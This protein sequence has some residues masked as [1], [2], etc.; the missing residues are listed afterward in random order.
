MTLKDPKRVQASKLLTLSPTKEHG[1]YNI[2]PE[3]LD[4]V[5]ELNDMGLATTGS[6]A[7]HGEA[8]C[9]LPYVIG[10][11]YPKQRRGFI[12]FARKLNASEV[13]LVRKH[14]K[15]HNLAG[16]RFDNTVG[17]GVG[18]QTVVRFQPIG[19]Q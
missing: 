9:R 16:I 6:C 7:G 4:V 5:L 12:K 14:L 3:I 18:P 1:P 8:H 17:S 10:K 2:D 13:A 19:R 15:S 11:G